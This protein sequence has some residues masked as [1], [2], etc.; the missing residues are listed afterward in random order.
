M[1]D[2][3]VG[4]AVVGGA[5]LMF[6]FASNWTISYIFHEGLRSIFPNRGTRATLIALATIA[7]WTTAGYYVYEAYF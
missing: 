4:I 3:Y 1:S 7:A 6:M 5:F 2:A